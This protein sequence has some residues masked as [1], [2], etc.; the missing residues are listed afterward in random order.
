M[1]GSRPIRTPSEPQPRART[2]FAQTQHFYAHRDLAE[3]GSNGLGISSP[4]N[5]LAAFRHCASPCGDSSSRMT[6][7]GAPSKIQGTTT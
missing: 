4:S 1:L 7:T 6:S 2:A 3:A 5:V